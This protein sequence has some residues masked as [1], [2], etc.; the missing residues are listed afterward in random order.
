MYIRPRI[1]TLA[2][3]ASPYPPPPPPHTENLPPGPAPAPETAPPPPAR[4]KR[5]YRVRKTA[6]GGF[7]LSIEKRASGKVVTIVHGVEGDGELLARELK[8]QCGVGGTY[9][10]G[11]VELQ[12]DVR[13]KVETLLRKWLA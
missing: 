2:P 6:K 7:H 5:P 9:D 1:A 3:P 10:D 12:G 4:E 13:G 8:K 11:A